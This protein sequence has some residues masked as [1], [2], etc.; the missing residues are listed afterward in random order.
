MPIF[1]LAGFNTIVFLIL[2]VYTLWVCEWAKRLL[3][4]R[5]T[6]FT[7]QVLN[8]HGRWVNDVLNFLWIC[9]QKQPKPT[10]CVCTLLQLCLVMLVPLHQS[11][12]LCRTKR[13]VEDF[14]QPRV[15]LF[16][17]DKVCHLVSC[18]SPVIPSPTEQQGQDRPQL[19]YRMYKCLFSCTVTMFSLHIRTRW[20]RAHDG[21][22]DRYINIA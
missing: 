10:R 19:Y 4:K 14:I 1:L 5:G 7:I 12:R 20:L 11:A 2:A 18:Q 6:G 8:K 17:V 15:S 3:Y 22:L 9:W 21:F 13:W 16:V